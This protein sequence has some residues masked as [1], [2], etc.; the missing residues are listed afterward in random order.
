MQ[1]TEFHSNHIKGRRNGEGDG[2]RQRERGRERGGEREEMGRETGWE[3][4]HPL[5]Q[6]PGSS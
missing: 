4:T 1:V 6:A 5:A 2:G 3:N